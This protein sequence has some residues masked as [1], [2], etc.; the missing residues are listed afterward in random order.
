VT[1]MWV[2]RLVGMWGGPVGQSLVQLT[3]DSSPGTTAR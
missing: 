2:L 3:V 1:R